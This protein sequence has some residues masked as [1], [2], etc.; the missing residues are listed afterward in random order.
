MGCT[1]DR[2]FRLQWT[3]IFW[4]WW[5]NMDN[6][7]VSTKSIV[8]LIIDFEILHI[9]CMISF[10]G[11]LAECLPCLVKFIFT[12][13]FNHLFSQYL[14]LVI[15]FLKLGTSGSIEDHHAP[16]CFLWMTSI[17]PVAYTSKTL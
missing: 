11:F 8:I 13:P 10:G 15:L 5:D 4:R 16:F 1:S 9:C 17:Y 6:D 2:Q 12:L 3:T 7:D 14:I